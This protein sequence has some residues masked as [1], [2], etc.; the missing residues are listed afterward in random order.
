MPEAMPGGAVSRLLE[1]RAL[2]PAVFQHLALPP[3]L[4]ECVTDGRPDRLNCGE[5]TF[6]THKQKSHLAGQSS[7]ILVP[8]GRHLLYLLLPCSI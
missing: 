3:A 5:S 2:S 7:S 8:V 4:R 1:A 6:G